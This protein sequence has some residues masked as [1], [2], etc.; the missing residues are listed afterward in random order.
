MSHEDE[1]SIKR[2]MVGVV[3]SVST[4]IGTGLIWGTRIDEQ[5][6]QLAEDLS[7]L[8]ITIQVRTADRYY[9]QDAERDWEFHLDK[10]HRGKD[11]EVPHTHQY[12]FDENHNRTSP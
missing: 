1:I 7:E 8:K 11:G 5:L 3:V 9:R 6:S 10:M 4:A 2:W 12:L